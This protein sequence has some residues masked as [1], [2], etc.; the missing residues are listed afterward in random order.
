MCTERLLVNIWWLSQTYQFFECML[1]VSNSTLFSPDITKV[2]FLCCHC[3]LLSWQLYFV[4]LCS[5]C[6]LPCNTAHVFSSTHSAVIY[7]RKMIEL[8]LFIAFI[9]NTCHYL[10]FFC[11]FLFITSGVSLRYIPK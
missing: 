6:L 5:L 9:E 10:R 11:S 4:L 8:S 7:F 2:G 3:L 1:S